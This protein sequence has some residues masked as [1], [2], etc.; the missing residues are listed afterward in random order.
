MTTHPAHGGKAPVS[1][2]PGPLH[3]APTLAVNEYKL[4]D[5]RG[6]YVAT[7]TFSVRFTFE[8]CQ[9]LIARISAS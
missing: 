7:V 5:V 8:Q 6:G 2:A 1:V 4:L 9:Q 3:W